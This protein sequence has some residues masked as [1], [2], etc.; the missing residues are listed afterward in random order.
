[1]PVLVTDVTLEISIIPEAE[2]KELRDKVA[3]ITGAAS[4]IGRS[5][6]VCAVQEGMR[7]VLADIEESALARTESEMKAMGATVL[8][9]V[10]DVS[11]AAD[12][13]ALAQ[14]TL[15][16][17]GAVHLLCNNAGVG[18]AGTIWEV[19]PAEWA[20]HINV[21]LWGVIH[22]VRTFVPIMLAQDTECHILNTSS[23]TGI[24]AYPGLGVYQV[25]KAGIVSL[26][27]TL[28]LE[29]LLCEAKIGVSVLC[30]G[31][32]NTRIWDCERTRSAEQ[33]EKGVG[34]MEDPD[35]LARKEGLRKAMENGM[36]PRQVAD[37]AFDA[38]KAGRFYIL[39][40]AAE[41]HLV[42]ARTENMLLGGQP[43]PPGFGA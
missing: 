18:K 22:G 7:V 32:V 28:Y 43:P 4:G 38:I 11:K 39:T 42:R 10:T 16:A 17:F 3:V 30:P 14:R 37:C 15:D 34:L 35:D 24:V 12:I 41:N 2:M 21:N 13:E 6:A 20:W 19:S 26:S 27:E 29:L 8:S 5:L 1:M 40:H 25:T 33:R 9:V 23:V 36:D 31:L